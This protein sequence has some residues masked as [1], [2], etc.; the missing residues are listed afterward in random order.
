MLERAR[1]GRER[2]LDL[3]QA[4]LEDPC[5][6]EELT[7]HEVGRVG[8]ALA[9]AYLEDRGYTLEEQNYRCSEGEADL[10]VFDEESEEIVLVEVKTRRVRRGARDMFPELAV[11]ERKRER[12]ARIAARFCMENFPVF[13]IRFDVIGVTLKPGP[14]AEV[15][16]LIGAYEW[17]SER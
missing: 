12:Y 6:L 17:D 16:H 5:A 9:L 8:E 4:T 7:A 10:I 3:L 15:E 13:A 14:Y 1:H 11:D 2:D